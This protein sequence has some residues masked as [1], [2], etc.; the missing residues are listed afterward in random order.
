MPAG[1]GSPTPPLDVRGGVAGLAAQYADMRALATAYDTAGNRMRDQAALGG[2]VLGDRDLLESGL[3]SP[4]SFAD[5]EAAVAAATTGPDGVLVAS[6]AWEADAVL[7]RVTVEAFESVDEMVRCTFEVADYG[8]GRI[9]GRGLSTAAVGGVL[10]APLWLPPLAATVGGAV[11]L[12][13]LLPPRLQARVR[14]SGGAITSGLGDDLQAWVTE[15]PELVQHLANGGGGLVD[16]FWDGLTPGV[17][18]G[19]DGMPAFTPTT[20]DAAG[21]LAGL[22]PPE[23]PPDVDVRSDLAGPSGHQQVPG[24]LAEVM[25]R[26]DQVNEWSSGD[27]PQNNGTFEIQSWVGA[28]G[29]PHHLVLLPGTDDM[30]TLPWTMDG[31]VRDMPT[32]LLA[33]NG[34]STAYAQGILT[35]MHDAGISPHDPVMLAGHSQG[36]I[37]AAWIA[38]HTNEFRITQVVTAGSPIAGLGHY[39]PGT[40]VLSLEHR[41][42]VMPLLGGDRN[43]DAINHVTVTL[44]EH[45]R[46]LSENHSI[47]AYADG[48][49]RIDRSDDPSL[50]GALRSMR[51]AGFLCGETED[52]TVQAFQI[53]RQR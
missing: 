21:V 24:S 34:Q 11:T 6:L 42:D 46:S 48:A 1:G 15:H 31:D 9:L 19:P 40:Q 41:G 49:A 44:D 10:T 23:G 17:P 5:A 28:Y 51:A 3:L 22:F 52:V 13:S 43:P 29:V 25:S 50:V 7:V 39:P 30:T 14:D 45:T 32:N 18:V 35:A 12:Y 26:L 47:T 33:V 36:G 4:L 2:R 20:Q 38:S 27:Q 37:E 16:G 53:T 8:V